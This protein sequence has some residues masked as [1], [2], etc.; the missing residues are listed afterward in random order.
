M[1][2]NTNNTTKPTPNSN[3][4]IALSITPTSTIKINNTT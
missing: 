2:N 3:I 1:R 4:I